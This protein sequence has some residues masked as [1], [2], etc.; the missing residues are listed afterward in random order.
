MD[1]S[2][3]RIL[4]PSIL[5]LWPSGIELL[6]YALQ[7]NGFLKGTASPRL[8]PFHLE[9]FSGERASEHD[10]LNAQAIVDYSR[11]LADAVAEV[12]H[13]GSFPVVLGGDCSIL[14]GC[15]LAL[16]RKGTYGLV[17]I[18]AHADFY[19]PESEPNGQAASMDLALVVGRG[20]DL[21]TNIDGQYPYTLEKHVVQIGQR[22]ADEAAKWG[23]DRIEDSNIRCFD[24]KTVHNEGIIPVLAKVK[25]HLLTENSRFW[26]HFDVDVLSDEIMPAVDYRL[27]GGLTFDEAST[28]L[29]TLMYCSLSQHI[30]IHQDITCPTPLGSLQVVE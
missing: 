10:V 24:L 12:R 22:D 7:L 11:Q 26:I 23:S 18:D 3:Q 9:T 5:G 21:L 1:R 13:Q 2:Y 14:F 19:G 17:H 30:F 15:M 29:Q 28:I 6:P 4:A 16:K 8:V 25:D 20:P 27:P